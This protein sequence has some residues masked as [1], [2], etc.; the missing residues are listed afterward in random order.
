[1][2]RGAGSREQDQA[3]RPPGDE[4]PLLYG[5]VLA[6]IIF[7]RADATDDFIACGVARWLA[8]RDF[9]QYRPS[10]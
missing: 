3:S 6:R 9:G 1:V 2:L 8:S 4:Y 10:G 5:P 7:E